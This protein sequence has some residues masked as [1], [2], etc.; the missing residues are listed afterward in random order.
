MSALALSGC[1]KD[2]PADHGVVTVEQEKN[3]NVHD[4]VDPNYVPPSSITAKSGTL[5]IHAID[6]ISLNGVFVEK[7]YEG[8]EITNRG[9]IIRGPLEIELVRGQIVGEWKNVTFVNPSVKGLTAE[10]LRHNEYG[11]PIR[12]RAKISY[13]PLEDKM[14]TCRGYMQNH[15]NL[16]P[17]K[18]TFVD[19]LCIFNIFSYLFKFKFW[20]MYTN[21]N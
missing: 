1:S 3:Q 9:R 7:K 12:P 8:R 11:T 21:D 6:K 2:K 17:S 13:L 20:C 10:S 14:I 15:T 19:R 16:D 18:S 4:G 5:I